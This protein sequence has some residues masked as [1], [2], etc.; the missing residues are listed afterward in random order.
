[1]NNVGANSKRLVSRVGLGIAAAALTASLATAQGLPPAGVL[2]A[3]ETPPVANA[4]KGS[5]LEERMVA[6]AAGKLG[7]TVGDGECTSLVDA[8]LRAGGFR[9]GKNYVWGFGVGPNTAIRKGHVIQFWSTVFKSGNSTWQT[10]IPGQHTAIVESASGK[11][12]TLLHQNDGARVVSRRVLDL[13]TL[14]QGKYVVYRPVP[15]WLG[16]MAS[17]PGG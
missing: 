16:A 13:A 2:K 9:P 6:Y 14:S 10:A 3:Q 17:P 7:Q 4:T 11:R 8:A 12:V 1:M 5:P 15:R